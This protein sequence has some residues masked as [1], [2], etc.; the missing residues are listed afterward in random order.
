MKVT[1]AKAP[2]RTKHLQQ[3]SLAEQVVQVYD[4][5]STHSQVSPGSRESKRE[6]E[7]IYILANRIDPGPIHDTEGPAHS[8]VHP[9]IYEFC[10]NGGN[11]SVLARRQCTFRRDQHGLLVPGRQSDV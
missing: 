5:L 2:E 8:Y 1:N 6:D 7:E 9:I 4:L 11:T 10:Y 3:G